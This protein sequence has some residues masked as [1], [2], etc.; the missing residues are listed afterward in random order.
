[1]TNSSARKTAASYRNFFEALPQIDLNNEIMCKKCGN[2]EW[3]L[4]Y[5][6]KSWIE[7][8]TDNKNEVREKVVLS[9]GIMRLECTCCG[10]QQWAK[11]LD[12]DQYDSMFKIYNDNNKTLIDSTDTP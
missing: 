4:E 5:Q 1:M 10:N 12:A 6:K 11:P 3:Q 9:S 8:E 2:V 7:P